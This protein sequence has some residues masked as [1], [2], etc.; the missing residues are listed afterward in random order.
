MQ[1]AESAAHRFRHGGAG[2]SRAP[3]PLAL[4]PKCAYTPKHASCY[5]RTRTSQMTLPAAV[6][7]DMHATAPHS[8]QTHANA[9]DTASYLPLVR[10]STCALPASRPAGSSLHSHSRRTGSG[11]GR[12]AAP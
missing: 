4:Q 8:A 1:L 12:A 5:T 6:C 2:A 7:S 11:A 9:R 10:A 3:S